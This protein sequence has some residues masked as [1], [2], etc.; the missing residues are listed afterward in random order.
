MLNR[1]KPQKKVSTINNSPS[2]NIVSEGTKVTGNVHAHADIRVSG[3]IDG[4][5]LSKGKMIITE[6][7]KVNGNIT[8]SDA[9]I[10]GK[11]EG[12]VRVSNKLIL[13]KSAVID[14]NIY[15]KTLIVEEGAEINGACRMG[16][17]SNKLS[18]MSDAEFEK[19]THLKAS[20]S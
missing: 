11:V 9:D 8:S 1:N 20:G 5:A 17:R 14:G 16:E 7:G 6:I 18:Q 3:T 13:R 15:T 19:G 2:V 10:A 4:E 12:E